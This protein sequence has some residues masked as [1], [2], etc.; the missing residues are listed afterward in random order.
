M[1]LSNRILRCWP[2]SSLDTTKDDVIYQT[3]KDSYTHRL[4]CSIIHGKSDLEQ[5]FSANMVDDDTV[6]PNFSKRYE[7]FITTVVKTNK[8]VPRSFSCVCA[9]TNSSCMPCYHL[10]P[11][12]IVVN[13]TS[14]ADNCTKFSMMHLKYGHLDVMDVIH[15]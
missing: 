15:P 2:C 10:C 7:A 12:N 13:N 5:L 3:G 1:H 9:F 6:D 8:D 4:L 11:C 14:I